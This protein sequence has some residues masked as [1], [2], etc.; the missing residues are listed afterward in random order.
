MAITQHPGADPHDEVLEPFD[1]LPLTVSPARETASNQFD[2]IGRRHSAAFPA[3]NESYPGRFRPV[4]TENGTLRTKWQ[5]RAA[6][7]PRMLPDPDRA[8]RRSPQSD[9]GQGIAAKPGG[10]P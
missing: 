10:Q 2:L 6:S 9:D 4:S 8:F 3:V 5:G 1:E 7:R